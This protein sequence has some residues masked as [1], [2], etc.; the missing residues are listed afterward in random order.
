MAK[1][2]EIT[3]LLVDDEDA[4]REIMKGFFTRKGFHTLEAE[5]GQKALDVIKN[6]EKVDLIISDFQMPDLDG[7][8]LFDQIKASSGSMPKFIFLSGYTDKSTDELIS[9]GV[10]AVFE[11][12]I[13]RKALL[14]KVKN[15]FEIE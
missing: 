3:I 13:D 8:G 2:N 10:S 4:L 15:L 1:A 6:V 9:N 5:N 7:L 14:A 12:P 11:K